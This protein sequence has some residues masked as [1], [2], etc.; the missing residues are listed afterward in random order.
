MKSPLPLRDGVG[1]SS[2]VLPAGDW[3]S[4]LDFL[5]HRFPGI[6]AGVWQQ[7]AACGELV[8][9]AGRA[10]AVEAPCRAGRQLHYYRS[11]EQEPEIPFAAEILHRDA[12]LLVVDK[13]HFLP[14]LP[15]GRYLQQTLLVRLKR[16]LGLADLVPL[17]RI[18]RGTAGLVVFSLNPETRG[19]YQQLFPK[20]EVEKTYEALAPALPDTDFPRVHRSRL[21]EGEP[22]FRMRE[23]EGA[24]NSETRIAVLERRGAL[25]LYGL[26]PVTGRK[27]QLRVHLAALGAPIVH[28]DFYP[29]LREVAD[30]D[31]SHPLQ[32]LARR[33]RFNDPLDGR[34]HCY[35]S[36]RQLGA[37]EAERASR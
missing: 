27:H 32:L 21:V 6:E 11:L 10:V 33:L 17:H 36:R 8:D 1:A 13:P 4:V 12:H 22:F 28:D 23:A 3:P 25:S 35:E 29:E 24:P 18:D 20:R 5:V 7:R 31:F 14:V 2:I 19:A 37:T 34:A 15:A 30:D 16:E 9:D 26:E